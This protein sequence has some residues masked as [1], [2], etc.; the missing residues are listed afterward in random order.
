MPFVSKLVLG[1]GGTL[2]AALASPAAAAP[3]PKTRLVNCQAGSCLVVTG[4]RAHPNSAVSIN[5][6]R[7]SVDG[8]YKWRAI[9]PVETLRQWSPP[10]ARTISVS[11]VDAGTRTEESTKAI[12]PIG[13]LGH[14]ENL[15]MLVVR[16]K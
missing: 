10:Y 6:N 4:H 5:G 1:L 16:V 2:A 3:E 9:L 12:L 11:V 7:V 8:A 14:A 13:L 15:A